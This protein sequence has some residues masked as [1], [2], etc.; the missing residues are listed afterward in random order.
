MWRKTQSQASSHWPCRRK[1]VLVVLVLVL[2]SGAPPGWT[3]DGQLIDGIAAVVNDDIITI[4]E[5]REAMAAETGGLQEQDSG[6]VP[7]GQLSSLYDRL[8]RELVDVR[9]QLARARELNLQV[10]DD[11]VTYHIDR[12]K[13]QNQISEAQLEQMLESRGLTIETYRQQVREGLLVAKVVNAEVRSRLVVMDTE[14]RE[15]Y[16]K[17][18]DR[19]SIPGE[20]TVSHILFLVPPDASS[21]E[22]A[23]ARQK[24]SRVLQALRQGGDFAELARQY[25]EGPS[26]ERD[27][28]LGTFRVGELLPGFEEAAAA[29]DPGEISD[30]V[31]TRAGLHIIRVEDRKAGGYRSLE[32]VKE[33]IKADLLQAK[34]ERRYEEWLE[35]LRQSAY[36]KILYEG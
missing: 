35:T 34:T 25:S 14:L 20:L 6:S 19:Y 32:E 5:V 10:S 33:E 22:A 30:I 23:Q 28:L 36:V 4:S 17:R 26:A 9:I 21:E 3:Q 2:A 12:L 31:R 7:Q 8:L 11:D 13:E 29:L 1:A 18:Q 15:E 16:N 27:G 24:A